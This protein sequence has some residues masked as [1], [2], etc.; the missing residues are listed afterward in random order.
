MQ[1]T[2]YL[3]GEITQILD[4]IPWV[5]CASGNVL[6]EKPC[7][8]VGK[9]YILVD[10]LYIYNCIMEKNYVNFSLPFKNNFRHDE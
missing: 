5:R 6:E 7:M 4:A 8:Y 9:L 10:K 2:F 1:V 3:A